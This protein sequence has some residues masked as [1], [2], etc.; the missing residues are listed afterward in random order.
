MCDMIKPSF[1]P[2]L[3][4]RQLRDLMRYRTKLTNM[5]TSEKNRALNCLTVSNLKLDDVFSDV[6]GKSSTSI[7]QYLLEHPGESF[8]VRPFI[9]AR[10]KTPVE[11]IQAAVEGAISVPQAIKLRQCLNHINEIEKHREE[12]NLEIQALAEPFSPV[13]ELLRTIPGLDTQPI[14]AIAILFRNRTGYVR[15]SNFE[16]LYF[17]GWML[18]KK[19]SQCPTNKIN[20]YL[21]CRAV[22]ETAT[23]TD[24]QCSSQIQRTSRI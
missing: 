20:T 18:S 5:K 7:I 10:C 21:S 11:E 6:F 12:I 4:I 1:I 24:C 23:C 15:V 16:T 13:L 9:H 3:E 8:D 22:V 17:L 14:T 2:G 19:R